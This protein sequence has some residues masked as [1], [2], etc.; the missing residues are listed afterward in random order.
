MKTK[1]NPLLSLLALLIIFSACEKET[2]FENGTMP[3]VTTG[4]ANF[5]LAGT[6]GNCL[7]PTILGTYSAGLATNNSNKIAVTVNVTDTGS[8]SIASGSLNGISFT[9]SG[10]FNTKGSQT[11]TLAA[12]GTP[13]SGGAFGYILGS[14]GCNFS[15]TFGGNTNPPPVIPPVAGAC[16]SCSY[17]PMC[18]GSK[19][20]YADTTYGQITAR[21]TEY[22]SST[23]TTVDGKI[24]QKIT[25]ISG[26]ASYLNCANGETTLLGF[27][28]VSNNGN[29]LQKFL[30]IMLK[31]NA[32]VGATWSDTQSYLGQSIQQNYKIEKKGISK[33]LNGFTF[34]DI[35][36]V[37]VDKGLT[38]P[39]IGFVSAGITYYY[40]A[41]GIGLV[42]V[43][44]IDPLSGSIFY[45]SV[46]KSYFIP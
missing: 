29:T 37:S 19:Y 13:L 4:T 38:V 27:A 24:F 10:Y 6:P 36:E 2:S 25:D 11:I 46:I 34:N 16:K 44:G 41:K 33:T 32:A 22:I 40:Y 15:I 30:T 45:H 17:I 14:N 26:Q 3:G 39:G 35:I 43:T 7:A 31:A 9:A 21:I 12:S 20:E 23:D 5:S 18:V 42:E 28:L 1:F 8:Y